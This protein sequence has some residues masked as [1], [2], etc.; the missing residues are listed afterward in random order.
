MNTDWTVC[1]NCGSTMPCDEVCEECGHVDSI[2]C[3][4][5]HCKSIESNAQLNPDDG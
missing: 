5:E 4:C 1:P 2:S 3:P